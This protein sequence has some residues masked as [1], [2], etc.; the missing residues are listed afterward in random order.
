MTKLEAAALKY[1]RALKLSNE[2]DLKAYTSHG[3][4]PMHDAFKGDLRQVN[5][6]FHQ[7]HGLLCMEAAA[8]LAE[9][10][11]KASR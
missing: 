2:T 7:A 11:K 8:F 9:Q 4:R 6:E 1:A 5:D 3:P 10:E